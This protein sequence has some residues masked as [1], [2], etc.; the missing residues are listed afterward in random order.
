MHSI[1]NNKRTD[2]KRN[3]P[4]ALLHRRL[5]ASDPP[6]NLSKIKNDRNVQLRWFPYPILHLHQPLQLL[7][8]TQLETLP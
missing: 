3:K 8:L 6:I 1:R 5:A 4:T 7:Q 2:P